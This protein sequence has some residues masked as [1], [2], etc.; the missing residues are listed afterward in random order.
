M[1]DALSP[2]EIALHLRGAAPGVA[3]ECIALTGSTNADLLQ[4]LPQL[5]GPLLLA[6]EVQTAGRGRAG[7]SWLAEPHASLTFSLAWPFLRRDIAGLLGLPLAVGVAVAEA[8]AGFGVAASLKWPNDVQLGEAKLGG[9][10]IETGVVRQ[11]GRRQP[12]AVIGIGLNI[13]LM[14]QSR[15]EIGREVAQ[16]PQL[17]DRRNELLAA[18]AARLAHTLASFDAAGFAPFADNWN[19]LHAHAGQ[20]VRIL[21]HGRVVQEGR[22]IGVDGSGCLLLDTPA[23][24]VTIAAGDVSLRAMPDAAAVARS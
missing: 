8:L 16:M 5:E 2:K 11:P 7:R 12:W 23:G 18:L 19:R 22:A 21:D 9:I 1:N 14:P 3:I 13:L 15:A 24:P 20:M 4:R 17:L 10:L 6:A